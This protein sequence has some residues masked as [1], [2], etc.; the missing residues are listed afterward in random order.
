MASN[1]HKVYVRLGGPDGYLLIYKRKKHAIKGDMGDSI[2]NLFPDQLGLAY[3]D[4]KLNTVYSLTVTLKKT[5]GT[6]DTV[7]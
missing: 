3:G 5:G 7:S 2:A 1:R 4:I 6:I